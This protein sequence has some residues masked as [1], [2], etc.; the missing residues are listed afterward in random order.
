MLAD[1][2]VRGGPAIQQRHHGRGLR[3]G[4]R[5]YPGGSP[6]IRF[7]SR[8]VIVF[9][10]MAR[11][12]RGPSAPWVGL[13]VDEENGP[14]HPK[15]MPSKSWAR[16]HVVVYGHSEAPGCRQRRSNSCMR[17]KSTTW[18]AARGLG[19]AART[20]RARASARGKSRLPPGEGDDPEPQPPLRVRRVGR[21]FYFYSMLTPETF[22]GR[23]RRKCNRAHDRATKSIKNIE[24][25][26][27]LHRGIF[28]N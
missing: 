23:R 19:P 9:A 20:R 21:L 6:S 18:P 11:L 5:L 24:I 17:A 3:R 10:D 27:H 26:R 12:K 1:Y 4:L 14:G 16:N 2:L 28:P 22:G 15:T 25:D 13:G 7:L 8:S